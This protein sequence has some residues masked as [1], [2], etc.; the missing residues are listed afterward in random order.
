MEGITPNKWNDASVELPRDYKP[1]EDCIIVALITH[2]T[3]KK[4]IKTYDTFTMEHM[5]V[6]GG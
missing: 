6:T 5:L 1:L 2:N 3:G 4:K